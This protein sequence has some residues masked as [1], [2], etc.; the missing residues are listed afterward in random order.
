MPDLP[1]AIALVRWYR[2]RA[3]H[4]DGPY[5]AGAGAEGAQPLSVDALARSNEGLV[6]LRRGLEA[7]TA[8]AEAAPRDGE[9]A[10]LAA[11]YCLLL[12]HAKHCAKRDS[13]C[14]E[15]ADGC[16]DGDGWVSEA[17]VEA[18]RRAAAL[19]PPSSVSYIQAK[20]ALERATRQRAADAA[21]A[22][23]LKRDALDT[24][25]R[26]SG[27]PLTTTFEDALDT[28]RK[29]G[30]VREVERRSVHSLSCAEFADRYAHTGTPVII[31]D[32][33]GVCGA[34]K[35][36]TVS[37][38][39]RL[40]GTRTV[41]LKRLTSTSSRWARLDD[42]G[43][44]SLAAFLD[45]IPGWERGS[46][47]TPGV[48]PHR[49]R[50]PPASRALGGSGGPPVKH[51]AGGFG[52]VLSTG[53]SGTISR[54]ALRAATQA[55]NLQP[56]TT[57]TG[58]ADDASETTHLRNLYLHD[59]GLPAA[60]PDLLD[61]LDV[62]I[63]R[64][65]CGDLLQRCP[66]GSLYRE[67]WPSLFVAKPGLRSG[68]HVDTFGSHF[69]MVLHEGR[70]RWV[71]FDAEE[72]PLLY[73]HWAPND[74]AL[75]PTFGVDPVVSPDMRTMPA[76][77]MTRPRECILRAGE[78]LF[79]PAGSP[80]YVE[81]VGDGPT[82]ALSGNFVDRT[83]LTTALSELDHLAGVDPRAAELAKAMRASSVG[84]DGA[85]FDRDLPWRDF[86][87]SFTTTAEERGSAS[88]DASTHGQ[89]SACKRA[90]TD[91]A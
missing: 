26:P 29:I 55:V 63:P 47:G 11:S 40:A 71:F 56:A 57:T 38:L 70:K 54:E 79:V 69:W 34:S 61:K 41:P 67:S 7:A 74:N 44:A 62:H 20:L 4:R 18:I 91:A 72:L 23:A 48:A 49:E 21:R 68:L 73:P 88:S 86:K 80:H 42:A 22:S 83:N 39:R 31:T 9:A 85:A 82:V 19:L 24:R 10:W 28:A 77:T 33:D 84:T 37:A 81:N 15:P 89:S 8:E 75:E 2:R 35:A 50:D 51:A 76:F 13:D 27:A 52:V 36:W 30:R 78:V 12:D 3:R 53:P 58:A 43:S 14:P 1:A 64:Y 65:F 59:W 5:S 17:A 16:M 32:M 60:A 45:S 66:P 6:F 46:T 90:R 87:S 25:K